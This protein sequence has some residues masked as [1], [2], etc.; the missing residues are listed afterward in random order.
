MCLMKVVRPSRALMIGISWPDSCSN[1]AF[2][3]DDCSLHHRTVSM[4]KW[5]PSMAQEEAL[6]RQVNL[7]L[8]SFKAPCEKVKTLAAMEMMA[9]V[10]CVD[11]VSMSSAMFGVS[12][13]LFISCLLFIG[14][15]EYKAAVGTAECLSFLIDSVSYVEGNICITLYAL[16][17]PKD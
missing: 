12:V 6:T 4:S 3:S 9:A 13:N 7:L 1:G 10:G 17:F 14:E 2:A 5:R 16:H 15:T 8:S 11:R